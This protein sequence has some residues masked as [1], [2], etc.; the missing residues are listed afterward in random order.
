M[1]TFRLLTH[2]GARSGLR[3]FKYH[4]LATVINHVC[5]HLHQGQHFSVLGTQNVVHSKDAWSR[6]YT[7]QI[8]IKYKVVLD[9]VKNLNVP[10]VESTDCKRNVLDF[11]SFYYNHENQTG[12][13]TVDTSMSIMDL[14]QIHIIRRFNGFIPQIQEHLTKSDSFKK[15]LET[16]PDHIENISITDQIDIYMGLELLGVSDTNLTMSLL[17]CN[18]YK[19]DSIGMLE[20][21]KINAIFSCKSISVFHM[22]SV[23]MPKFRYLLKNNSICNHEDCKALALMLQNGYHLN[24]FSSY[25][26]ACNQMF[27]YADQFNDIDLTLKILRAVFSCGIRFKFYDALQEHQYLF[28]SLGKLLYWLQLQIETLTSSQIVDFLSEFQTSS[29]KWIN[30]NY[31]KIWQCVCK[32]ANICIKEILSGNLML[33][34]KVNYLYLMSAMTARATG[35]FPEQEEI[36]YMMNK[37]IPGANL[38]TIYQLC[39]LTYTLNKVAC[40]PR[41]PLNQYTLN[42]AK[43]LLHIINSQPTYFFEIDGVKMLECLKNLLHTRLSFNEAL[44]D[45]DTYLLWLLESGHACP[46]QNFF[47]ICRCSIP[48]LGYKMPIFVKDEIKRLISESYG[49]SDWNYIIEVLK[50]ID[51]TTI[52]SKRNFKYFEDILRLITI[53]L[54]HERLD[55]TTVFLLVHKINFLMYNNLNINHFRKAVA[56]QIIIEKFPLWE[57]MLKKRVASYISETN[58]NKLLEIVFKR[59]MSGNPVRGDSVE[60]FSLLIHMFYEMSRRPKKKYLLEKLSRDVYDNNFDNSHNS[61][62]MIVF[63]H[64]L[65]C[66]GIYLDP[67]IQKV[68]SK[69]YLEKLNAQLAK[70]LPHKQMAFMSR[71]A[72]LNKKVVLH[73]QELNIPWICGDTLN[74][75][76]PYFTLKLHPTV[77]Y[78]NVELH[79]N[80]L[81]GYSFVMPNVK[82]Q[83]GIYIDFELYLDSTNE[84]VVYEMAKKMENSKSDIQKIAVN[85]SR[86]TLKEYLAED[87]EEIS[88][89]NANMIK[90]LNAVG[91]KAVLIQ[92]HEWHPLSFEERQDFLKEKI[93]K[94]TEK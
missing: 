36:M 82:A 9:R 94:R 14:Y 40:G 73:R 64:V 76:H 26:V 15:L 41:A 11:V 81:L 45:F 71:F 16:L 5:R 74:D 75:V 7:S 17:F 72:G 23:I 34:E 88:M 59:H 65:C 8:S 10:Q 19:E 20:L 47:N 32:R 61:M 66:L 6:R 35:F 37:T 77:S 21:A 1:Y 12:Q 92:G 49:G 79:L 33:E 2:F 90:D 43:K 58:A 4:R 55:A 70:E 48:I 67:Y 91:Y 3:S 22:K 31:P 27:K 13:K 87:P 52:F 60:V 89:F 86:R 80:I 53:K 50:G 85:I 68:F 56:D 24:D 63:L 46:R 93:F 25:I 62:F 84:P 18:F 54:Q 51:S 39:S 69:N 44:L 38:K 57:Q 42:L 30:L 83:Y 78:A 29:V 28:S